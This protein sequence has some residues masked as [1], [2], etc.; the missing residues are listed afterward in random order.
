MSSSFDETDEQKQTRLNGKEIDLKNSK[1][2]GW[3]CTIILLGITSQ[4]A[5]T[6]S[7]F[8]LISNQRL[9]TLI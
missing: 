4:K 2:G 8:I 1:T 6:D 5:E 3:T 7:F 9:D